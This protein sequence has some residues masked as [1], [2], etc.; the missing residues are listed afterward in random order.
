MNKKHLLF[1]VCFVSLLSLFSFYGQVH[2][3]YYGFSG[4]LPLQYIWDEATSNATPPAEQVI[5]NVTGE[6]V[7]DNK[8]PRKEATGEN[9]VFQRYFDEYIQPQT[10]QGLSDQVKQH[11]SQ[12]QKQCPSLDTYKEQTQQDYLFMRC[13][14]GGGFNNQRNLLSTCLWLSYMFNRILVLHPIKILPVHNPGFLSANET[15]DNIAADVFFDTTNIKGL[16]AWIHYDE[17]YQQKKIIKTGKKVSKE[18]TTMHGEYL[19]DLG[20]HWVTGWDFTEEQE[21]G[22]DPKRVEVMQLFPNPIS[23]GLQLK[24][25]RNFDLFVRTINNPHLIEMQFMKQGALGFIDKRQ[26]ECYKWL[27][28]LT[29]PFSDEVWKAAM[30]IVD[31][32]GGPLGYSSFHIRRGDFVEMDKNLNSSHVPTKNILHWMNAM[33]ESTDRDQRHVAPGETVYVATDDSNKEE[34]LRD[35]VD[36]WRGQVHSSDSVA[37]LIKK[38]DNMPNDFLGCVEQIV[39]S[40]AR[41]FYSSPG[42]TFAGNILLLRNTLGSKFIPDKQVL[43]PLLPAHFWQRSVIKNGLTSYQY[44]HLMCQGVNL[45]CVQAYSLQLRKLPRDQWDQV[46]SNLKKKNV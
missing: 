42:S 40:L 28:A 45:H 5:L 6:W 31:H 19:K 39:C 34:F 24:K 27:M 7:T 25:A 41:N 15:D 43:F 8:P 36:G 2:S 1:V 20:Q 33:A 13:Y 23:Q 26:L 38:Y 29:N 12:F 17:F 14:P 22:L 44:L 10:T 21:R 9:L 16:M 35:M 46:I 18:A 4:S 11:L 30:A 32:L 37:H 3:Y